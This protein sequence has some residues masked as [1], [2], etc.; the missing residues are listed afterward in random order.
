M[1]RGS[2]VRVV[3]AAVFLFP[4]T[5]AATPRAA[6]ACGS[7]LYLSHHSEPRVVAPSPSELVAQAEEALSQGKQARAAATALQAYPALKIVKVGTLPLA[8]RALRILALA[9]VRSDGG[10]S[11]GNFASKTAADRA[12]NLEW[13]I[14]VLRGLDERHVNNPTYQ[15]DLGEALARVPAHHEEAEKLLGSLADRDLLTS[16]EGYAALARLRAERGD[17]AARDAMV[18]RCEVMTKT[19]AV[20]VVPAAGSV[21]GQT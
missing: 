11:T 6:R 20:C 2:L 19:P 8:D 4:A 21:T 10:L 9:S 7:M 1:L 18:Q 14:E 17:Q 5:I 13:S 3:W 16:A 12:A 15:T